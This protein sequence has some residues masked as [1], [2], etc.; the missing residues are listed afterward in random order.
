MPVMVVALCKH[1]YADLKPASFLQYSDTVLPQ[2][3]FRLSKNQENSHH[4]THVLG[5]VAAGMV[6]ILHAVQMGFGKPSWVQSPWFGVWMPSCPVPEV[7]HPPGQQQV[8][9]H[10]LLAVVEGEMC[11][12]GLHGQFSIYWVFWSVLLFLS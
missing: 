4:P 9:E 12:E 5:L 11:Q 2:S 6:H 3:H 7:H 1:R 10:H 8:W